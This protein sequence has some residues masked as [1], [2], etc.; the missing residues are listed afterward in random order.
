M[1]YFDRLQE[2]QRRLDS[3]RRFIEPINPLSNLPPDETKNIFHDKIALMQDQ[4]MQDATAPFTTLG[5]AELVRRGVKAIPAVK[6]ILNAWDKSQEFRNKLNGLLDNDTVKSL[7]KDPEGTLSSLGEE[8]K[9]KVLQAMSDGISSVKDQI[10]SIGADL[11]RGAKEALLGGPRE[12]DPEDA[13]LQRQLD[14]SYQD[15]APDLANKTTDDDADLQRQLDESYRDPAQQDGGD[16]FLDATDMTGQV[17]SA[18][19]RSLARQARAIQGRNMQADWAFGKDSEGNVVWKEPQVGEDI[20]TIG[21]R[22]AQLEALTDRAKQLSGNIDN[23]IAE[24]K[25]RGV[26]FSGPGEQL[27]AQRAAG[28]VGQSARGTGPMDVAPKGSA[29]AAQIEKINAQQNT[30]EGLKA[31][32]AAEAKEAAASGGGPDLEDLAADGDADEAA[33]AVSG[34][35]AIPGIGL[36]AASAPIFAIVGEAVKSYKDKA[37]LAKQ[38]AAQSEREQAIQKDIATEQA[39]LVGEARNQATTQFSRPA[40][41]SQPTPVPVGQVGSDIRS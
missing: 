9:G 35:D 16:E 19:A 5:A 17:D 28:E 2:A 36:L 12:P 23:T 1:T 20:E 18:T 3:K 15:E 25:S 32:I 27:D 14:E 8:A 41:S 26:S 34:L 33:A 37:D 38:Q 21:A 13:D 39:E 40:P 30:A 6:D 24:L 31:D 10:P 29:E 7:L 4:I 22:Q 11:A